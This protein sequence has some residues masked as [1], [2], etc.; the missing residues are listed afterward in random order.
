MPNDFVLLIS[1]YGYLAI[2]LLIFAQ[3]VGLPSPLPN[4][5]LLLFSGYLTF[6]GVLSIPIVVAVIVLGDLLAGTVLYGV[7]YFFGKSILTNKPKWLPLPQKKIERISSRI[8][9]NGQS[10][11]FI[12]RLTPL[13]RGYVAVACGL[14]QFPGK[15][16]FSVIISTSFI[17]ALIYVIIGFYIGPYWEFLANN[18]SK[19]IEFYLA[20][21]AAVFVAGM[22]I[23]L[24]LKKIMHKSSL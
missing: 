8:Q 18:G 9:I 12:G 19:N 2:F 5:F 6:T 13:I 17:W 1:E 4:E 22:G 16:Y 20:V 21:I 3:E 14:F 23:F 7:F 11:V 10:S 24:L 15:K